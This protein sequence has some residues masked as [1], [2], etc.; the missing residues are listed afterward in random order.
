MS[1]SEILEEKHERNRRQRYAFIKE[2]AEY[3]RTHPDDD[4][5]EQ[6]NTVVDSQLESARHFE[7]ERPNL[8]NLDSPL[9]DDG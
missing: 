7:D 6:V 9:L 4:W 2:W 3:V 1:N 5:G 8:D